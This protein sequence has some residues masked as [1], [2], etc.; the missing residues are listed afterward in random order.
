MASERQIEA[1][2][3][4]MGLVF[5][6]LEKMKRFRLSREAKAKADKNRQRI[7]AEFL[8][9]THAQRQ[10]AAQQRREEKVRERKERILAE[11]DPDK[12]RKLEEVERKREMKEKRPRMKQLKIKQMWNENVFLFLCYWY[13]DIFHFILIGNLIPK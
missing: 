5:H 6:L 1:M 2:H 9:M 4:L 12:Q 8:K 3:P 10:E 13:F 7:E 11:E